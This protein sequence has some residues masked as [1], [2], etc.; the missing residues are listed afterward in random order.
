MPAKVDRPDFVLDKDGKKVPRTDSPLSR[1]GSVKSHA[2]RLS[3][4]PFSEIPAADAARFLTQFAAA[5]YRVQV[6]DCHLLL[7]EK[8]LRTKW[9][10]FN[11]DVRK[12]RILLLGRS[13]FRSNCCSARDGQFPRPSV[14]SLA[15]PPDLCI[16]GAMDRHPNRRVARAQDAASGAAAVARNRE[17][18]ASLK[19]NPSFDLR[20]DT[21]VQSPAQ[22]MK[23]MQNYSGLR[24]VLEALSLPAIARLSATWKVVKPKQRAQLKELQDFSASV[25]WATIRDTKPPVLPPVQL[26][27]DAVDGI[28]VRKRSGAIFVLFGPL[29]VSF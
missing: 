14:R 7:P 15:D 9:T 20:S 3:R 4:I 11:Q 22:L 1:S 29:L 10:A 28:A 12:S 13:L 16:D 25:S 21:D 26:L 5:K 23:E 17:G 27:F 18:K 19:P 8:A 24:E 2:R 6:W